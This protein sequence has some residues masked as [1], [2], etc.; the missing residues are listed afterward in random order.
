ME[1]TGISPRMAS[2]AH[3]RFQVEEQ[4]A[5]GNMSTRPGRE[6]SWLIAKCSLLIVLFEGKKRRTSRLQTFTAFFE[7]AGA[8][9][10]SN[11]LA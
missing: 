9:G 7:A 3:T 2:R 5:R 4:P 11:P 10:N 1:L 6:S 8:E